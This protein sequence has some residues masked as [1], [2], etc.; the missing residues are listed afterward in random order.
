MRI[1]IS[2]LMALCLAAAA[3]SY[4]FGIEAS[5]RGSDLVFT[6]ESDGWFATDPCARSLEIIT[7]DEKAFRPVWRIEQRHGG[8]SVCAPF[9]IAY[10]KVPAGLRQSVA[11]EALKPGVDYEIVA[12]SGNSDGFGSFRISAENPRTIERPD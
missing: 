11:A 6:A 7:R 9:P 2:G 5:F 8:E 10:G 12:G 3:C 1:T 4:A